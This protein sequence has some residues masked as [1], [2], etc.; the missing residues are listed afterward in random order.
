MFVR[1]LPFLTGSLLTLVSLRVIMSTRLYRDLFQYITKYA[2]QTD[3][4]GYLLST[5][6]LSDHDPFGRRRAHVWPH[7]NVQVAV[8]KTVEVDVDLTPI[9]EERPLP[10]DEYKQTVTVRSKAEMELITAELQMKKDLHI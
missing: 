4:S 7:Q 10:H 9:D 2:S 5:V 8:H 1:T 6:L 3:N